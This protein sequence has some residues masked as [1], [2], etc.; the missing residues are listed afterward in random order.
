MNITTYLDGIE[1]LR[2]MG[3]DDTEY[4]NWHGVEY[5]HTDDDSLGYL[6]GMAS[7]TL[8]EQMVLY[9]NTNQK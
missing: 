6:I 1:Y 9:S 4:P 5:P 2:A 3:N 8:F 7:N